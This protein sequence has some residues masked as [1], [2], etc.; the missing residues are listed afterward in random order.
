MLKNFAG[1]IGLILS[2]VVVAYPQNV[3]LEGELRAIYKNLDIAMKLRDANKVTQF[4]DVD[5]TL[6]SNGK[7]LN[8]VETVAQWKEIL[9]FIKSVS[10]LM[11]KI[12]KIDVKDGV[13]VVDYSQTS[14]GRIQFP[15][16]PILPFTFEGKITD[17]WQRDKNGKW[18]NLSSVEHRSDLK[19][20]GDSTKPPGT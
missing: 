12:E 4:Y 18:K 16:S 5:Y 3:S 8:R 10:K 9:G 7:K 17:K 13:Y 19:V 1:L 20:N 15:Q 14:S 11:T 6:E 2:F